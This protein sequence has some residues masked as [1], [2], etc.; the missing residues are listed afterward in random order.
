MDKEIEP[1]NC[2][3]GDKT[4]NERLKWA[5]NVIQQLSNHADLKKDC[6]IVLASAKYREF[7][8]SHLSTYENPL[9]GLRIGEQMHYLDQ[10]TR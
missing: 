2:F 4:R 9:K 8:L 6:F 1:Y 7:L 3:L 5:N 10:C